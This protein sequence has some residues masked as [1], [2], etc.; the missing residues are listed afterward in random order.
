MRKRIEDYIPE[1]IKAIRETGIA[2]K[3]GEVP[4]QF[5]GYISSFAASVRQAGLLSTVL[6]FTNTSSRSEEPREKIVY[7]LEKILGTSL[8]Q[9]GQVARGVTRDKVDDACTAL[10]LA[11]RT[12]KLAKEKKS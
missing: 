12:F 4:S 5:N 10:K 7:A 1:A 8:L 2:D 6:F 3:N 9:G 11:I